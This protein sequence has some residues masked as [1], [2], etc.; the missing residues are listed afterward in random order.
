MG[1]GAKSLTSRLMQD[2]NAFFVR[3]R[4]KNSNL[5]VTRAI[6][7]RCDSDDAFSFLT[8]MV[9]PSLPTFSF[10]YTHTDLHPDGHTPLSFT[11]KDM[12][13]LLQFHSQTS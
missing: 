5:L 10:L 3:F 11:T 1:G 2:T 8:L 9:I 6:F 12:P 7:G 13:K 4:E